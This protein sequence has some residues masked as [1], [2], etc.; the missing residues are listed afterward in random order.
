MI[1]C[2]LSDVDMSLGAFGFSCILMYNERKVTYVPI[3][4][5]EGHI[6]SSALFDARP[7]TMLEWY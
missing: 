3:R 5:R 2:M 4:D 7:D 6:V 1:P